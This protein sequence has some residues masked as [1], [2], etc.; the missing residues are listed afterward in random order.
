MKQYSQRFGELR[1]KRQAVGMTL[2]EDYLAQR[3]LERVRLWPQE[4]TAVRNSTVLHLERNAIDGARGPQR[5]TLSRA[6]LTTTA[7]SGGLTA[8]ACSRRQRLRDL[9]LFQWSEC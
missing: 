6:P 2:P 5:Q 1:R 7:W 9:A 8:Q 4:E 3:L